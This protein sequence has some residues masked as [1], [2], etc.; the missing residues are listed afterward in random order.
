MN[1]PLN[2]VVL[3]ISFFLLMT[4]FSKAEQVVFSEINYNPRGDKP[5]F[6]EIYNLTATPKDI[7]KWKMTEGIEYEFPNF[8]EADP[9][10]TFLEK[11][12]RILLSSVDEKALRE[13]YEIPASTKIYGPWE[14][15]LN[16]GGESL[17]LE[18]KNGVVMAQ[19]EYGDDGRKW[20]ISADGSGHTLRLINQ[21]RGASYWKNWGASLAPDGTPGS[22]PAEEDGQTNKII[23]LGSV[24]KYDQS[25]VDNGT[26]WK[27]PEYD[28]SS[29]EE[30]PGIFGKEGLSNKM[31]DPGFQTPWTTGGRFTYYL[32]KEFEWGVP[33]RSAEMI[34]DGLFDDGI[35]VYLNG[36]EIGRNSMPAGVI[37]WQ[38]PGIRTEAK[39][40]TILE[41]D[42]SGYLKTGKNVLAVEIHNERSGSSDIVFGADV[43]I[44]TIPPDLSNLLVL[45]EVHF[46]EEGNVDW[47]EL[48]APGQQVVDLDGF[49][50]ASKTDFSDRITLTGSVEGGG[51]I[52]F[53]SDFEL[54]DNGNIEIYILLGDT[55]VDAHP[56]DRDLGEESFQSSP[57][58]REWYG[59]QGNTKG[60]PNTA[61]IN[62]DIVINEIMYDAPSDGRSAEYI[63]LYN[64]SEKGVDLSG[65]EFV[66][67]INF[68]FPEG[69][70]IQSKDYLV[71]AADIDWMRRHYGDI[72][73]IGNFS[74]QLRDSGEL[75]RI[76]DASGNLVDE[77][78]YYPSG[79]WPEKADGDGSSMELKHPDMDNSSPVAWADSDESNTAEFKTFTYNDIFD[80]V[81]WSPLTSGQELHMHLVGDSHIEV[82]NI[83]IQRNGS[84][85]NLVKNPSVMSPDSSSAKGWVCQGTHWASFIENG[86]LNLISDG[87]G[88][89]KANRAEVDI[90]NLKFDDNYTLSFDARWVWGK[91]RLIAQ[92]LDH[93][94]GSSFLVP[95]P[96]NLGTPGK[97]N[98]QSI[99]TSAPVLFDVFHSP[100]VPKPTDRVK[101]TAKV[102]SSGKLDYVRVRHRL[103]SNNNNGTW[104]RTTMYDDGSSGGDVI[105][106]DGI[107][108][109]LLT[110]YNKQ[111][112][113]AQFYVESSSQDSQVTMMP[114]LG[115]DRPAMFIVDGREM[116][117]NLL[118][119]R[120]ILS[121]YDRRALSSGGG[122]SY[123]Y[124]FPRMS[125]HYFN[126]TFIANESEIFYNA[127]I[128]K[129][130][131]PFTRDGGASLAHGKWKLPGDR[132]F[133]E[134]RR[135]VFDASGTSEGSGTPRFY[136][137][138]IARH[139]LYQLGH[140]VNEMEFVHFA[141]NGDAF[142]LRENHE[143]ISNDF[144]NRNFDNGSE[145][146]LLRID[147]EWR[148]TGD[149]GNARQSRN[150]DWSYKSSDNPI[151]YHS[152]WLMRSREQDY[153][154]SNFIE[155]VKA[156]GT[157]KFDED[158][159]SRMA[160]RDMLCI[161]AAVRGYDAD[162]DTITLN[163]GKN[164]YF[165]RPKG[166]R[167]MLIHWDGD[168]V[169]GNA[170]ETF[171]GGLS[172]IRTYFDKP[173]IRRHLN[174][175]LTELLT[176]LTKDSA[177]TEA[178]MQ[179]ETESVAGT[180]INMT[181][182]HYRNWFRSRER[183][184][185]NFIGAPFRTEFKIST[186]S[187]FTNKSEFTLNGTSPSTVYDIRVAG[188]YSTQ[189]DWTS[190][191][192]WALS[193]IK[194]KEGQND[195]MVEAVNHEGKIVYSE[196]FKIT[197]REDSPPVIVVE[198]NPS[199]RNLM[200]T[201]S[202]EFDAS[203]SFDPE[204]TEMTYDWS[205]SPESGV[206][207]SSNQA[208]AV[209]SFSQP[210]R[211]LVN[212]EIKDQ[213]ESKT[214]T[215]REVVVYGDKGFSSFKSDYLD[216]YWELQNIS[217]EDNTPEQGVYNLETLEGQLH[218]RIPG[219]RDFPLGLPNVKLPDS[220]NYI[221][222]TDQW[223][224]NDKNEDIGPEFSTL[225]YDDSG[226]STGSG[227]FGVDTGT[228]PSPGLQTPLNRD[229]TNNL[230]TYYFRKEFEFKDD[231]IGSMINIEAILDDGAR[232]WIN[233]QEI[234]RVRLPAYPEEVNW[235]TRATSNVPFRD[236]KKLLQIASIDGSGFLVEGK[237]VFAIDLHNSSPGSSDIV[238]GATLDIAA[239]PA[240]AGGGG[241]GGT[242]HPWLKRDLPDDED[243]MLQTKLDLYGLQF[244]D[245]LTG[246]M[247]EVEREG[248]RFRYGL[249][250]DSGNKLSVTQVTPAAT[251]GT[252][253]SLDYALTSEMIIRI[254]RVGDDLIFEWR[255]QDVFE[256]VY[257]LSLP[258]GSKV[259]NGG[260]FAATQSPLE[261][262]V[263]FDYVLLSTPS[264]T[265]DY[266]GDLVIS[267]LMY[268]PE[269]GSNYEFIELYNSGK[270]TVDLDGFRFNPGEPFDEYVFDKVIIEPGS[271]KLLVS[272]L[273][274]FRSKYGS[275]LDEL[276]IGEWGG[277][278]LSNG[279]EVITLTDN[280]GLMVFSFSYNDSSP[281]PESPDKDGT[282]LT[283]LDPNAG[284]L[285]NPLNW[286]SS[287]SVGGSPGGVEK[288]SAFLNW[289]NDREEI[290]PLAVK[291]GET[292]NNF[293][294]YAFGLDLIEIDNEDAVPSPSS[295][296]IDGKEYLSLKFL[297]R[298][299]D[300]ALQYKIQ[301][302][303]DGK[304]WIDA[305]DQMQT[306]SE[307]YLEDVV[308][309]LTV[310]MKDE[311]G[312][313]G[314][315]FLR[316]VV[317]YN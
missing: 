196:E 187:S 305:N 64:K 16:N 145:G 51:Y 272:N 232:F 162:W 184:A 213:G 222:L 173:Y 306:V 316:V 131:S 283:L 13:A 161:N 261:L 211:Y 281:W 119:E 137:D 98:S 308:K 41:S 254:K 32:R 115:P 148:F 195:L 150:A 106:N 71:V 120:L 53:D 240:G 168:R 223:S 247:I 27:D 118:R 69:T 25:G 206:S 86:T 257:R 165:Y 125:N 113:I 171:L 246:L 8:N 231:P 204:G 218:I 164:A 238:V 229:S 6:I 313:I 278:S 26:A 76:E 193:G 82:K 62:T 194:L 63:E 123:G 59:G 209:I 103:D 11:W 149:D 70:V 219:Y 279:G 280:N 2:L 95:I 291:K 96:N 289:L 30:G 203:K 262:N 55:V 33:F 4:L 110:N 228:F 1:Y 282:S 156:I 205:V 294:T 266:S 15:N 190:T 237:N 250:N 180:G 31:P 23:G 100:A 255:P 121:N 230:L 217:L 44:T 183:A 12:E 24:W 3:K 94:F 163:R 157:R 20:P 169:F 221:K 34:I 88:D 35:V 57:P 201:D 179:F 124:K 182:S 304:N 92:T 99:N 21:N 271:Y 87:H 50:V 199:S 181:S 153:D 141:V 298:N 191:T 202:I 108:T 155:F 48:H 42:V 85:A 310:R 197:K 263:M 265:S 140:P 81:T 307:I 90:N 220:K 129:S 259:I 241:L 151:Q 45:S 67:G 77:V 84:G 58:G 200:M 18:D 177:L 40:K 290:D 68:E 267:E 14:G 166:G 22:G 273:E 136:D 253:F 146:T 109:A 296:M 314:K 97:K 248:M 154:Y 175:Y 299:S 226:W 207:I 236:E 134:R 130:G 285:S 214:N 10:I 245:F 38:T 167:W 61:N 158:S 147:D 293:L 174:Y 128:R 317:Q 73:V 192:A 287:I 28:D 198:S 17:V 242:I 160:D 138:R 9:S 91:S 159:I 185:Q 49:S 112:N 269:D 258:Q 212:L 301:L 208:I 5:E 135:N 75:L 284:G 104:S 249:G 66:D 65:W 292:V 251:T 170:G 300:K 132:L 270:K 256:E 126:A 215:V 244:G 127:E 19:V 227:I 39:Y 143:P 210:G 79:D 105:A 234:T 36:K 56:F 274:A 78:Y 268:K 239:Q 133:R 101:I 47:I 176:K 83:S 172:G 111:G 107:Y 216:D 189:C 43:A 102:K 286:T 276:I 72:S 52:A 144:L 122:S 46:S 89:N 116:K 312:S 243:W 235:K 93:G 264:S 275:G 186:R 178:W 260:P 288:V 225:D 309:V 224:Y 80:R 311:L 277:G 188:Q 315:T 303:E 302:S 117:D 142:K 114:K 233:G 7:S 295:V 29:W 297:Q 60:L 252:L 139:F 37:D 74:G 152:E 54:R